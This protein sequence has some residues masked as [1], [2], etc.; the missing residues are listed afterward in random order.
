M[1]YVVERFEDFTSAVSLASKYILKIKSF[2]MREFGLKAAHVTCLHLLGRRE[3]GLTATQICQLCHEDKAA[4]SKTLNALCAKGYVIGVVGGA[5]KYKAVYMLSSS[6]KEISRRVDKFIANTVESCG[7]GL[8]DKERAVFYKS[9]RTI[10][11]NLEMLSAKL[12][13]TK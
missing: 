3:E 4:V 11:S 10:I 13:G 6:G 5:R 1:R 9:F 2:Y 7:K 8:T 12:E